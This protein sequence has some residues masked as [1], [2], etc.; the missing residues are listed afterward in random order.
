MPKLVSSS[1]LFLLMHV[2]CVA[3]TEDK[4][5]NVLWLI[6]EDFGP[7]LGCDGTPQVW[8]PNL[9]RLAAEG[10]HSGRRPAP[11]REEVSTRGHFDGDQ[12]TIAFR[13]SK[14][15]GEQRRFSL[16][17]ELQHRTELRKRTPPWHPRH[18]L[19]LLLSCP[20]V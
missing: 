5:P 8:T 2:T 15:E 12:P 7:H 10:L 18:H 1:V 20:R 16:S 9:D 11:A 3:G 13:Q 19:P 6:A 4:R 17:S 14:P